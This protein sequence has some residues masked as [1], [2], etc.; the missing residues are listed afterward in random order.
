MKMVAVL[1]EFDS[2]SPPPLL[3]RPFSRVICLLFPQI[4]L[5][6]KLAGTDHFSKVVSK[7]QKWIKLSRRWRA[8]KTNN[9][10]CYRVVSLVLTGIEAASLRNR[11]TWCKLIET[12]WGE[13]KNYQF[14]PGELNDIYCWRGK[15]WITLWFIWIKILELLPTTVA[16][17]YW[18][19]WMKVRI[20][21]A[22]TPK[23]LPRGL[24]LW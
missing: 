3:L 8:K 14:E 6:P 23:V 18:C 16:C 12:L 10:E 5:R 2:R 9:T 21:C 7:G 15:L 1:I 19:W 20:C 17:C 11:H 13:N 4:E 22:H 24:H